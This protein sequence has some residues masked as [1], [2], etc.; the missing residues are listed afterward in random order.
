MFGGRRSANH[1]TTV[2]LSRLLLLLLLLTHSVIVAGS[3]NYPTLARDSSVTRFLSFVRLFY[4]HFGYMC[5]I[6][7]IYTT[8][9]S[10]LGYEILC[11]CHPR[12]RL[13]YDLAYPQSDTRQE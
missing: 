7:C 6:I 13:F 8:V 10:N 3:F 1:P 11:L 4:I 9:Y 2:R 5:I 12:V